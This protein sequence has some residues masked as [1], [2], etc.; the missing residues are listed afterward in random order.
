M[1]KSTFNLVVTGL[2]LEMKKLGKN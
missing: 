1:L 2:H